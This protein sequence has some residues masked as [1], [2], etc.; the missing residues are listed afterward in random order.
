ML[1]SNGYANRAAAK[2]AFD[3][4]ALDAACFDLATE[5]DWG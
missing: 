5:I 3:V 1:D 2:H 4:D